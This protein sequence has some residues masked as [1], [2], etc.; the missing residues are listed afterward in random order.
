MSDTHPGGG[1]WLG[2]VRYLVYPSQ[3]HGD[4][5]VTVLL[6]QKTHKLSP[7]QVTVLVNSSVGHLS[8]Y[9]QVQGINYHH[10]LVCPLPLP[11]SP[12]TFHFGTKSPSSG[13]C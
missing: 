6:R 7:Y 13:T 1:Q 12:I 8:I 5:L 2:L 3:G 9:L 10:A 11:I 4:L